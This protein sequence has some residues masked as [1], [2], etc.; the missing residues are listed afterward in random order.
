MINF[1]SI[2]E[3]THK[4]YDEAIAFCKPDTYG[5]GFIIMYTVQLALFLPLLLQVI[6]NYQAFLRGAIKCYLV[7]YVII[8]V[9]QLTNSIIILILSRHGMN[10][11]ALNDLNDLMS[12]LF[13]ISSS[14]V[15]EASMFK[16]KQ[17][18]IVISRCNL[19]SEEVR[20]SPQNEM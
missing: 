9:A 17:I 14:A 16:I 2:M 5:Y 20:T 1:E 8:M 7:S 10:K 6:K 13:W 15:L 19:T 18:E 3:D 12:F 4:V 11:T